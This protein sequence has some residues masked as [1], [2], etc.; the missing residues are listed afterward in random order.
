VTNLTRKRSASIG[1]TAAARRCPIAVRIAISGRRD[2]TD[3]ARTP[4]TPMTVTSVPTIEKPTSSCLAKIRD[5]CESARMSSSVFTCSTETVASTERNSR[6]MASIAVRGSAAVRTT[7]FFENALACQNER[8]T[9]G[10]GGCVRSP[11]RPF[12]ATP[13]ISVAGRSR[14][15]P[16]IQRQIDRLEENL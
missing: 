8:Q 13:M 4:Y 16:Q 12:P 15:S 7:R 6:L 10:D 2:A 14:P 5:A 11:G 1:S 3:S 9:S